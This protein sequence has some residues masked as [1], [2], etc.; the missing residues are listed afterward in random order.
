MKFWTLLLILLAVLLVLN[1]SAP[2]T[3]KGVSLD[4]SKKIENDISTQFND[5][6]IRSLNY[7]EQNSSKIIAF[8]SLNPNS[9]CPSLVEMEYNLN[10]I[11]S[12]KI[13]LVKDC[14]VSGPI[15]QPEEAII[16]SSKDLDVQNIISKGGRA[17]AS[18][19]DVIDTTCCPLL[20]TGV[21]DFTKTL[22]RDPYWLVL[23]QQ[24]SDKKFIALDEVG[25]IIP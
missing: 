2:S 8:V 14:N 18:K 23:W 20:W 13:Y 10:P 21:N 19:P 16:A 6:C 17:C 5:F 15:I 24:G 3:S 4:I 22:K 9:N 25:N 1:L 12:R 7:S 11:Y